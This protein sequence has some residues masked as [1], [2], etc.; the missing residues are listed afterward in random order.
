MSTP[1]PSD[2]DAENDVVGRRPGGGVRH[3]VLHLGPRTSISCD[4]NEPPVV[5][6]P[7]ADDR[8]N[9]TYQPF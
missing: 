8:L 3:E 2:G 1:V 5:A 4:G 7:L 6:E 9:F